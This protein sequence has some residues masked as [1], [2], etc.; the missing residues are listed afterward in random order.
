MIVAAPLLLTILK[1][2][3]YLPKPLLNLQAYGSI[4]YAY[5]NGDGVERNNKKANHY[6]ELEA[7]GGDVAAR[8]N[9][10]TSEFRARNWDRALKHYMIAAGVGYNES[11]KGI[12]QLYMAGLATKAD[13]TCALRAYQ[14]CMEILRVPRGTKLLNSLIDTNTTYE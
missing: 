1:H 9:L 10:G 2:S 3:S 7:I 14:K 13:Y 5:Y 4:G 8:H 6:C 12:Q 11:V